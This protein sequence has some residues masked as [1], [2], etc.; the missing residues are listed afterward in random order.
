[1]NKSKA[2]TDTTEQDTEQGQKPDS[3]NHERY[4]LATN[5]MR[6]WTVWLAIG[7][8][9]LVYT[10]LCRTTFRSFA[11]Q[12]IDEGES[13]HEVS[14]SSRHFF[15]FQAILSVLATHQLMLTQ[16]DYTIDCNSSSYQAYKVAAYIFIF[17]YPVGVPACFGLLLYKN[18]AVLGSHASGGQNAGKWWYGDSETF[19]FLVNGYRQDTFWCD[20]SSP[21]HPIL[22]VILK[23]DHN[24]RFELVEFL[25]KLLMAGTRHLFSHI[26]NQ[27]HY[28]SVMFTSKTLVQMMNANLIK[29]FTHLQHRGWVSKSIGYSCKDSFGLPMKLVQFNCKSSSS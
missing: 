6:D 24:N 3:D 13:F 27:V 17:I 16:T 20:I 5:A 29:T 1:M 22:R 8:L 11:C 26:T 18:R 25:R 14:Q 19:H 28:K 10:I 15:I 12:E 23:N 2:S 21:A 4:S 9:F 7:W